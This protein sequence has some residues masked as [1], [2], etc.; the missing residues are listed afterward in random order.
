[1]SEVVRRRLRQVAWTL[2]VVAAVGVVV[3]LRTYETYDVPNIPLPNLK[4]R[5]LDGRTFQLPS[6]A[7]EPWLL[8]LWVPG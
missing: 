5:T 1:M 2:G 6:L 4:A 8:N 7:G 3:A